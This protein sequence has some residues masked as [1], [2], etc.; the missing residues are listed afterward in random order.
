MKNWMEHARQRLVPLRKQ[1]AEIAE[2]N[3]DG[4]SAVS[5][6]AGAQVLVK[7]SEISPVEKKSASRRDI[8]T[9]P[10]LKKHHYGKRG[11]LL[12]TLAKE[13]GK[14]FSF[15]A[16]HLLMLGGTCPHYGKRDFKGCLLWQVIVAEPDLDKIST[17]E[18]IPGILVADAL[19]WLKNSDESPNLFKKD[20][21]WILVLGAISKGK[22]TPLF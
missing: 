16:A 13:S 5:A 18:I 22:A 14:R 17:I 6:E 2:T 8:R 9:G 10:P 19:I 11:K 1:P 21:R 3:S 20:R 4:V 15:C 7:N 12:E